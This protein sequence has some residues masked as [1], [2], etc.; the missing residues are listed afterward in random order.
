MNSRFD[1]LNTL[2]FNIDTSLASLRNNVDTYSRNVEVLS[3]LHDIIL[4]HS[5]EA[6]DANDFLFDLNQALTER[7]LELE[8]EQNF[9]GSNVVDL[10]RQIETQKTQIA[11]LNEKIQ[12]MQ[13]N[14]DKELEKVQQRASVQ[15]N[16]I[17]KL[18]SDMSQNNKR[19][20]EVGDKL[21]LYQKKM[22][23]TKRK[24]EEEFKRVNSN[25]K[26][27]DSL[28]S[29]LQSLQQERA[30]N[31]IMISS[32][33]TLPTPP[34]SE[35]NDESLAKRRR[36]TEVDALLENQQNLKRG[37]RKNLKKKC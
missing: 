33:S 30:Q 32:V 37:G 28:M 12:L 36:Q 7:V 1:S 4:K 6:D 15:K 5:A 26:T 9:V 24:R 17:E 8:N 18:D 20:S 27:R 22:T 10:S 11:T 14:I 3:S 23:A 31:E 29:R 13:D 2:F 35:N 16:F 21:S 34:M 25:I 19:F